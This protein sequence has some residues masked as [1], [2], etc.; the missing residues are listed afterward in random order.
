[1][2]GDK[3]T[4][5]NE[6]K[7]FYDTEGY[8]H[9]P[10]VVSE[11]E[12]QSIEKIYNDFLEGRVEGVG[13][14]MSDI[15]TEKNKSPSDYRA[16]SVMVPSLY[17]PDLAQHVLFK[18]VSH[19]VSQLLGD[20]MMLDFDRIIAKKPQQP[21]NAFPW[22]QDEKYC[23]SHGAIDD[24]M[25]M[26]ITDKRSAT[27]SLALDDTCEANGCIQYVRQSHMEP[28]LRT[29][30]KMLPQEKTY[31]A[32]TR[33]GLQEGDQV[34]SV[35]VKRG[36]ITIHGSRIVH[37]SQGNQTDGWRRNYLLTFSSQEAVAARVAAGYVN[38]SLKVVERV[39]ANQHTTVVA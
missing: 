20:G 13:M 27:I 30:E 31:L 1:M 21:A 34:V 38:R 14:D 6:Q 37:G 39:E 8:L 28:T 25:K 12:L 36:D 35:P 3:Y 7:A 24:E 32:V 23:S 19:V 15:G 2:D 29:H 26:K 16:V 33:T 22:H 11:Q 10:T 5:S 9:L 4:L 18:R 17:A